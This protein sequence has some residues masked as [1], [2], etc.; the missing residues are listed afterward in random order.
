LGFETY[1]NLFDESYDMDLDR[2]SRLRKVVN[3]VRS[4]NYIEFDSL[5]NQKTKHNHQLFFNIQIIQNRIKQ[6]IIDP[7]TDFFEKS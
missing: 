7:I 5:T 3:N 1:E 2:S 6:E 4:F